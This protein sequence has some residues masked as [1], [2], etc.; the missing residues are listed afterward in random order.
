MKN[1]L[2]GA[3]TLARQA[4]AALDANPR[5][6]STDDLYN[7]LF[8]DDD[9]ARDRVKDVLQGVGD[10]IPADSNPGTD[11]WDENEIVSFISIINDWQSISKLNDIAHCFVG[12]LL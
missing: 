9:Q 10:R 1:A 5:A 4:H 6:Q 3:G 2:L 12:D 11:R 8:D 7:K